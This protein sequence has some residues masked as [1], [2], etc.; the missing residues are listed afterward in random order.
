ME[1]TQEQ[2]AKLRSEL[3]VVNVNMTVLRELTGGL[4]PGQEPTEDHQLIRELHSTCKEM[5][6]RI[7]ELIPVVA[8]EEITCIHFRN[9]AKNPFNS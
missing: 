8:N 9:S 4:K 2:M 1:A 7:L 6:K 3:D 5:Q